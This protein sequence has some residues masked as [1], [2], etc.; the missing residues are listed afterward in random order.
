MAGLV[1]AYLAGKRLPV[2]GVVAWFAAGN[3][4]LVRKCPGEWLPTWPASVYLWRGLLLG[5]PRGTVA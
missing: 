2:A 5:L 1:V 4:G 3:R